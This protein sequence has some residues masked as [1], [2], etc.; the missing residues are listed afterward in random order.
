[1][2]KGQDGV[3]SKSLIDLVLLRRDMLRYAQDVRAVRG[4]GRGLSDHHVLLCKFW[5]VVAWIKKRK[6]VA[7]VRRIR[8]EKL[9]EHQY[10]EGYARS[11]EREGSRMGRR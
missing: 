8:R 2:A 4:M 7:G 11:L 6:V 10:R 5:L 9:R 1:M 3:E